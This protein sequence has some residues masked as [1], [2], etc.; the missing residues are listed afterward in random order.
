MEGTVGSGVETEKEEKSANSPT[1]DGADD[2][3]PLNVKKDEGN[4]RNTRVTARTLSKGKWT[5]EEDE[6]LRDAVQQFNGKCWKGIAK[7]L[8]GR[9][10]VQCLHRWQKVINPE[11]NKGLWT[12]EEDDVLIELVGKQGNKKWS[13]VAKHLPGRIGKQCRD[14]WHNHLNPEIN[15]GAWTKEED[16][17]LINAHAV[18]GN[19][20]AEMTKLLPGR[21]ENSIKNRWNCSLNKKFANSTACGF[22]LNHPG[23]D[24]P[25]LHT[26]GPHC[27]SN[28][29]VDNKRNGDSGSLDLFLGH[30]ERTRIHLQSSENGSST[31]VLS[32]QANYPMKLL[33]STCNLIEMFHYGSHSTDISEVKQSK[34]LDHGYCHKHELSS[35]LPQAVPSKYK[36]KCLCYQPLREDDMKIFMSSGRF[37]STDSYIRPPISTPTSCMKVTQVPHSSPESILKTA[38]VSYDNKPSIIR[39]RAIQVSQQACSKSTSEA[40]DKIMDSLSNLLLEAHKSPNAVDDQYQALRRPL[41]SSLKYQ[42]LEKNAAIKSVGKCLERAFD[43][44]WESESTDIKNSV[45]NSNH[46]DHDSDSLTKSS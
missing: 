20:W 1:A 19:K 41:H 24:I 30:P 33:S 10:D 29:K 31:I 22:A 39:K 15:K 7:C 35:S 34:V 37:P 26:P 8:P 13:E 32:G 44:L 9:T 36:P 38:A 43:V 17:I 40:P 5:K 11:L 42:K 18:Y 27:L 46:A 23:F 21:P 2:H 12:K 45:V 28:Q 3:K 16:E 6:T 25:A 4:K 14:R